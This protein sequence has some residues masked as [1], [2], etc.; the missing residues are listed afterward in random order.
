MAV[1]RARRT[2]VGLLARTATG[3]DPVTCTGTTGSSA[4]T[5][6]FL[7]AG[8]SAAAAGRRAFALDVVQDAVEIGGHLALAGHAVKPG[9]FTITPTHDEVALDHVGTLT[10]LGSPDEVVA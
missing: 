6:L 2:A 10:V 4:R 9:L 3:L 1:Q 8:Y 5:S 7:S